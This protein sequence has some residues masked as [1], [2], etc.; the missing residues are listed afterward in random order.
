MLIDFGKRWLRPYFNRNLDL[1]VQTFN[2]LLLFGVAAGAIMAVVSAI[3]TMDNMIVLVNLLLS[4]FALL[5]LHV[6]EKKGCYHLCGMAVVIV[7]FLVAFP[8]LFFHTGGHRGGMPYF[9]MLAILYTTFLLEKPERFVIHTF[10]ILVFLTCFFISF[11]EPQMLYAFPSES[12]YVVDAMAGFLVS[13]TLLLNIAFIRSRMVQAKHSQI[14]E[15]LRT[16]ETQNELLERYDKMKS[17]FLATVAHEINTPLAVI[18]ASSSDTIDL[19]N[20]SPLDRDL[21]LENQAI[22]ERRV[23]LIDSILLDLMDTVAIENGRL[24]LNRKPVDLSPYLRRICEAHGK[25]LDMGGNR[26]FYS[27]QSALPPVWIDPLRIEQV[28]VNLLSNAARHTVSGVIT[29]GLA[30]AGDAQIVSVTDT[31]EGM[32]EEMA[33][34]ALLQYASTKPDYWRHGIGLHVCRRIILAHGG[35]IWINSEKGRG[36]AV[37]FSLKEGVYHE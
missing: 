25:L 16:F 31:G 14:Q 24:L 2:L 19:L 29:I 34:T 15:M 5:V 20:E 10:E 35:E 36:T 8:I 23:K 17:D 30:N 32:D 33:Q 13:S 27:L 21:I 3:Q 28:M 11:R 26:Y 7:V 22:I 12:G 1:E 4:V 9:F 6:A 18:A 37:S